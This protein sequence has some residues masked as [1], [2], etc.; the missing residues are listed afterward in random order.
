M[1]NTITDKQIAL[2]N[3]LDAEN[4]MNGTTL[5]EYCYWH[6]LYEIHENDGV[7]VDRAFSWNGIENLSKAD[8][9]KVISAAID[10]ARLSRRES[11]RIKKSAISNGVFNEGD[12]VSNAIGW[13]GT[14][15]GIEGRTV[16]VNLD[17]GE[18]MK[19]LNTGLKIAE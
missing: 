14:V 16:T 18:T 9:S 4:P 19:F 3:K 17:N 2:L 12:R 7:D 5:S 6:M 8:A 13:T 11:A 15:V 1:S 10:F